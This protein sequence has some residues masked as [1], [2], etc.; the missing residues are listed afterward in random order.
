MAKMAKSLKVTVFAA[1]NRAR[2]EIFVG[3]STLPMHALIASLRTS[4]PAETR[5]WGP[6]DEVEYR[7]LEFELDATDAVDYIERYAAVREGWR[8]V[9]AERI[10]ES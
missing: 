5:S 10:I 2:R 4:P 1:T 7:S 9:K 3:T 6:H 8:V